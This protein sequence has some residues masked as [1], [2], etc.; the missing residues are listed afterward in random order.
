MS[1]RIQFVVG[2]MCY[3]SSAFELSVLGVHVFET[4]QE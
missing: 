3:E 4:F 1:V 2:R